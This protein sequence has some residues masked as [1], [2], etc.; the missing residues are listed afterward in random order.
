MIRVLS[1]L[2]LLGAAMPALAND[3]LAQRVA[4]ANRNLIYEGSF[5]THSDVTHCYLRIN[6]EKKISVTTGPNLIQGLIQPQGNYQTLY[7]WYLDSMGRYGLFGAPDKLRYESDNGNVYVI[8]FE[9]GNNHQ[10]RQ[11]SFRQAPSGQEE[12]CSD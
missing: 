3:P 5:R 10:L 11:L 4:D 1:L 12:T 8:E 7:G 6:E 2:V 9:P